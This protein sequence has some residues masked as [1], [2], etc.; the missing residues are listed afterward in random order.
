M[1]LVGGQ[2][3]YLYGNNGQITLNSNIYAICR[4]WNLKFGNK[5]KEEPVFGTDIPIINTEE[6]HG[7]FSMEV[8][9]SSEN[10]AANE[11]FT[12]LIVPVNGVVQP[13]NFVLVAKDNQ[14]NAR[15][16]TW[17]GA[18]FPGPACEIVGQGPQVIVAKLSGLFNARP[19]FT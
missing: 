10:S 8:I 2:S 5:L 6:Y 1:V 12:K 18:L 9:A 15:T 4:T 19:I 13:I 14:N 11:N 17:T 7:E 3:T 16:W